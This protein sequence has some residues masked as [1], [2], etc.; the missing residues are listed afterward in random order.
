[1][2]ALVE[3]ARVAL[4]AGR[5]STEMLSRICAIRLLVYSGSENVAATNRVAS[6]VGD[7]AIQR[8]EDAH[9]IRHGGAG[10]AHAS[11][12]WRDGCA[13]EGGSRRDSRGLC[14]GARC[15]ERRWWRRAR[16][17]IVKPASAGRRHTFS[18]RVEVAG[19]RLR[20]E[21][22][23]VACSGAAGATGAAT[24]YNPR[25][26]KVPALGCGRGGDPFGVPRRF[27]TGDALCMTA[28]VC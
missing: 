6:S 2:A 8:C 24:A 10:R 18:E 23:A 7:Y 22:L 14:G 3:A 21:R 11:V 16:R 28:V 5:R 25:S 17:R 4:S 1:M 20:W 12:G 19:P 27:G 15:A 13:G 9:C 26:C